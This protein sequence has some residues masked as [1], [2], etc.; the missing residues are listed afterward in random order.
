[1]ND[2]ILQGFVD[3]FA[4][5]R[6]LFN[7]P[8]SEV[9]EAFAASSIL[10]KYH[11]C[12]ITGMEHDILVDGKEDGG[13]DA[14]AILVNGT[15][16]STEEGPDHFYDRDSRLEVEFVF[17]QTK[18]SP[19]FNASDIGT[20]VFGVKEYFNAALGLNP[21][22]RF[23]SEIQ[24]KINLTSRIYKQ[25]IKMPRNPKCFLYYVTSGEWTGAYDPQGRL[26][27]GINQLHE[28]SLFSE[29][30][31]KPVDAGLLKAIYRDLDHR[32]FDREVQFNRAVPFPL[33]DKVEEAYIGVLPGDE[34]IKLISNDDGSLNRELFYDNVRDFQ[35][36][37]NTVNSEIGQ[38]LSDE[39]WRNTFPLLNNGVTIIARSLKRKGE[40]FLIEG[41]Q[42]VNGCQTT[43][44]LF[45]NKDVVRADTFIP[46]KLVVT[47]DS[48]VVNEVIKATNRQTAV[49]PEALE[50]LSTFHKAL[51]DLYNLREG[52]KPSSDRIYY[53]RRSKQYL[54]DNIHH[55]NIVTLTGQIKSFTGMFLDEPHSCSR[56][57][58]E[59]LKSYQGRI[60]AVD[61]RPG[62]YYASGVALVTLEK[63]LKSGSGWR[64][65]SHYK[66]HLL[67]LLRVLINGPENMPGLNHSDI[68]SYSLRIVDTLRDPKQ[69]DERFREAVGLLEESLKSFNTVS[70]VPPNYLREFTEHLKRGSR[71]QPVQHID[72]FSREARLG[73][74]EAGTIKVYDPV[75]RYGFITNDSGQDMFVHESQI[76]EV[77]DHRRV[78][79]Q[80]VRYEVVV[81][82]KD[83]D[84]RMM[85]G[86]VKPV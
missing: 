12:D 59:L 48:Q 82:P 85:A 21:K 5:S 79:G 34:F 6:S 8:D 83:P 63:W 72:D 76:S 3:D 16:V 14:I 2:L 17:M 73:N 71:G 86:N 28:L 78:P 19:R 70:N 11:Q 50:S 33:I 27:D 35:G 26:E 9:F 77:P 52:D 61:H 42:I 29:V 68:S 1:M 55:S 53:E 31:G 47:D 46:V 60:F 56:H 25:T 20:F 58:G 64:D 81:A 44:I 62:P 57:Y 67:M 4:K 84:G 18:A 10:R 74:F 80:Q 24:Q 38:T 49:L 54:F 23:R 51:E 41:F 75:K 37:D 43:H 13:I 15:P 40:S 36:Y 69:G 39:E 66:H 65:W 45:Q 22:V 32:N 7:R 30:Q